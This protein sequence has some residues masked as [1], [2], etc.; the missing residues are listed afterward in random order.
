MKALG[1][2]Y[3]TWRKSKGQSRIT[4]GVIKRNVTDGV[5]FQ[6]IQDGIRKAKTEGFTCFTDFPDTDKIYTENVLD[7]LGK[8]LTNPDREDIQKY[9]D[10]WEIKPEYKQD[11]FYLLA[12]TQG[13]LATDN[14]EFLADYSPIEGLSFISEICGLSHTNPSP[15]M[16]EEGE[17]LTWKLNKL[18]QFDSKA[19]GV[20]KG[21]FYLGNVKLIHCNV[22]HKSGGESLK[23]KVKSIEKNGHLNRVFINISF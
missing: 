18:N 8:R 11:K 22:F 16:V 2:I 12:H 9:Y 17:E 10:F 20:Y 15:N 5:R 21:N 13:L 23:I 7:I 4:V 19:V 3:L 14:F 1:N 6:Y